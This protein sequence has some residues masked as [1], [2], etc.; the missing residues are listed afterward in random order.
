MGQTYIYTVSEN[1]FALRILSLDHLPECG[2][3]I[4]TDPSPEC[5]FGVDGHT[6]P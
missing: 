4:Y 1:D 3:M 5:S 2:H 6:F